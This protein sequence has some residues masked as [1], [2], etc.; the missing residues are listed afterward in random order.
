MDFF[1]PELS[2]DL[3][4]VNHCCTVVV[5]Y[6]IEFRFW[7]AV[8][9]V[10]VSAPQVWA[11]AEREVVWAWAS[12]SPFVWGFPTTNA[13]AA[14]VSD[15]GFVSFF[16]F[17]RVRRSDRAERLEREQRDWVYSSA[18]LEI[19]YLLPERPACALLLCWHQQHL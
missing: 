6:A 5:N 17:A 16:P 12:Q 4:Q 18:R 19:V 13:F 3:E 8:V 7:M 9:V 11:V 15:C 1:C 14:V 2:A 10:T